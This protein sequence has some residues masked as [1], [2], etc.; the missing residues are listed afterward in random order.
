MTT[1]SVPKATLQR[2]PIYLKALRR[3]KK[4]GITRIMSKDLSRM[5]DIE[6]TTIRRDFS[7]LGNLGKQGYGYDVE[8]LI[9][10]FNQQLGVEFDE[11]I[12]LVGAG[13]LG[14]ALLNYNKWDHVV[15]EIKCGFDADDKKCGS[16]FGIEIYPMDQLEELIPEGC[17]IAILTI[18]HDVQKTVDR[19]VQCGITG[20]VDFTHQ[21]ISAP[22]GV[23]IK[24]VDV[25]SSIQEL[26]FIT[27]SIDKAT[28]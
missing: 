16:Q 3:L 28:K 20:I 7:F 13:N 21:H 5:I 6:P 11:K 1:I 24:A 2:Y 27:N 26:V 9:T 12:I 19:L 14:R 8:K 15:G 22:K 17:H 23:Y 18:S 4:N 10:V 25:V